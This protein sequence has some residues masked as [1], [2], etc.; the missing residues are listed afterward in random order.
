MTENDW[1]ELYTFQKQAWTG[2]AAK[3]AISDHV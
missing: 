2:A 1:Q 3:K